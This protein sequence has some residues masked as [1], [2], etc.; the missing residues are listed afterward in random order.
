[1]LLC[2]GSL[3]RDPHGSTIIY[4]MLNVVLC[5][6]QNHFDGFQIMT[7]HS[8]YIL[9]STRMRDEGQKDEDVVSFYI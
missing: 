9:G 1:V 8:V 2:G 4:V 3:K 5:N 6:T 7:I